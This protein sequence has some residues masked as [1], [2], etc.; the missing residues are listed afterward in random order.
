MLNI[1]AS[2][3]NQELLEDGLEGVRGREQSVLLGQKKV[4]SIK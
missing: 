4:V 1:E 3:E 2:V